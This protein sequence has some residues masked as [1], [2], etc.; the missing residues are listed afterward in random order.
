[1]Q[2]SAVLAD[3]DVMLT[4]LPGEHGSTF[5]GNPL[6]CRV[7]IAA[8]DVSLTVVCGL[9]CTSTC[10]Y[11]HVDITYLHS[12]VNS[13]SL[14]L[15][16]M[17]TCACGHVHTCIPSHTCSNAL[18]HMRTHICP[19]SHTYNTCAR[20]H[21]RMHTPKHISVMCIFSMCLKAW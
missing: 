6:A 14:P 16:G 17:H 15:M 18:L 8:L 21:T 4:I 12:Q 5:G 11:I 7:A 19:C 20:A 2:V 9:T 3:D 1:M 10:V 13:C